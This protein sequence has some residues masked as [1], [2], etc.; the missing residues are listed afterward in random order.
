VTYTK[1]EDIFAIH[2]KIRFAGS[3]K[4]NG[5]VLF[6]QMREGVTSLTPDSL[7]RAALEIHA[8]YIVETVEQEGRW[9]G[10]V[11][12]VAITFEKYVELIIPL[13]ETYVLITV[14]KEVPVESYGEIC[15]AIR[16]LDTT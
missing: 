4:R 10:P 6:L 5:Q 1:P 7:D 16:A 15:K 3:A 12:N 13:T 11:E 2:P 8:Q 14:E 9:S